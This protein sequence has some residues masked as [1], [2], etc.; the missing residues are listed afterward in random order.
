MLPSAGVATLTTGGVGVTVRRARAEPTAPS[1]SVTAATSV[2]VPSER[3]RVPFGPSAPSRLDVQRSRPVRSPSKSSLAVAA[4]RTAVPAATELPSAG[5]AMTTA[6]GAFGA[7]T[8]SVVCAWPR[9]PAESVTA[10]VTVCRPTLR[11]LAAIVAPVPRAPSRLDV[12]RIRLDSSP[13]SAWLACAV[14][15][16]PSCRKKT[17]PSAGA[18]IVTVGAL[19]ATVRTSLGAGPPSRD[20]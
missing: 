15:V 9:S 18:A 1:E 6:G 17:D 20:R 11:P 8:R 5:P 16:I 7:R 10:A 14:N 4:S 3:T 13:S 2:C 19:R 12:H